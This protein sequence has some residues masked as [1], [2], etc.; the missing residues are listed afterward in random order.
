MSLPLILIL[1]GA[2]A[3]ASAYAH[4]D[5]LI[6]WA[7]AVHA[8][9]DEDFPAIIH[10]SL[11]SLQVSTEGFSSLEA[12]GAALEFCH[13][14][15]PLPKALL[16]PCNSLQRLV[17]VRLQNHPLSSCKFYN[18]ETVYLDWSKSSPKQK[19]ML[20]SEA[21]RSMGFGKDR[22]TEYP[23]EET[24]KLVNSLIRKGL[25]GDLSGTSLLQELISGYNK[26]RKIV[27]LG[28][29]ELSLYSPLLQGE[30]VDT[31]HLGNLVLV[32]DLCGNT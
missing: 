28:C 10:V 8:N 15:T 24:Q 6:C 29:S 17:T 25:S 11:P 3:F 9:K 22:L 23:D 30:F 2:G 4:N 21:S 13:S 5:L 7:G 12:L 18:L 1:G 32:G 31:I 20:A 19:V 16:V 26:E 14:L 27:V